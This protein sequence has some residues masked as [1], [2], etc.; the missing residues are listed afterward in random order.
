MRFSCDFDVG[1]C[2]FL[3]IHMLIFRKSN[4]PASK[5]HENR[6]VW[7]Q[8][9]EVSELEKFDGIRRCYRNIRPVSQK[10]KEPINSGARDQ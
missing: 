6:I 5:S 2:D 3:K 9:I 4:E 10:A 1:S 7:T 8:P